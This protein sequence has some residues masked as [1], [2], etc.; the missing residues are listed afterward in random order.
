MAKMT[1]PFE[2]NDDPARKEFLVNQLT[3]I[4]M[5]LDEDLK[6]NWGK[7]SPQQM[8]EHLIW[9]FDISLG[10]IQ[11]PCSTPGNKIEAYKRFL[12]SNLPTKQNFRNPILGGVLPEL[13]FESLKDAIKGLQKKIGFF[14]DSNRPSAKEVQN[15]PI[16]GPLNLEEWE[17]SHYK[18]CFHH[19]QQFGLLE[20]E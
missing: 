11:V 20:A 18:H 9:T 15:H 4:L 7:M 17:R 12:K 10:I 5:D 6:P 16:F 1:M 13:Y 14:Y 19:L 2:V 3:A 8:V